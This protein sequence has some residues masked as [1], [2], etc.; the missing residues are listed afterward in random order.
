ME[1][2]ARRTI[3]GESSMRIHTS[4]P[5]ESLQRA[6]D[7]LGPW[8]YRFEFDN[9]A[10]TVSFADE[11][12]LGIH[13]SLAQCIFPF[14][15]EYFKGRWH[16]VSCLDVACHEGW[17]AFQIARRGARLVKGI[18]LRPERIDRARSAR[19]GAAGE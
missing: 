7:A 6:L 10:H 9:Q 14:L 12:A 1:T 2:E 19:G 11:N 16:D 13:T 8:F 18:D 17:F 5:A 3:T 4:L 15:D